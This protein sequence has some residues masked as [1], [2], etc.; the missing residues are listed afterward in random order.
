MIEENLANPTDE[1]IKKHIDFYYNAL[2]PQVELKLSSLTETY[3]E[4]KPLLHKDLSSPFL[5]TS[6]LNYAL[7]RLPPSIFFAKKILILQDTDQLKIAG[8]I[9][10]SWKK[11]TALSRRRSTFYNF[12]TQTLAFL[13]SS[14]S[15]IDDLINLLIA[16]FLEMDKIRQL[17]EKQFNKLIKNEDYSQLGIDDKKWQKLKKIITPDWQKKFSSILNQNNLIIKLHSRQEE[18]YHQTAKNWWLTSTSGLPIL[19]ISSSSVYLVSSNLHSLSNI[20]GTFVYTKQNEIFNYMAQNF[21]N[22]YKKW[23]RIKSTGDELRVNDFLYYI[24]SKYFQNNPEILKEKESFE[25]GI[26]IKTIKLGDKLPCDMQSIPIS[27]ITKAITVDPYLNISNKEKLSQSQA[28]IININ[29][30]LGHS[31]YYILSEILKRLD[32]IKGIYVIGKAAILSGSIGD[33]QIPKLVFDERTGNNFLIKNVFNQESQFTVTKSRI[34]KNQKAVTVYGTFLESQKQLEA[35]MKDDFNIIEM[36][37][38]PCLNAIS[39]FLSKEKHTNE[40]IK[41]DQGSID[42]GIINYAS[43]N[44]LSKTLG[45]GPLAIKGA[46]PTYL[47]ALTVMQRIVDLELQTS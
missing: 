47:S 43:D 12:F 21:P 10:K 29:Y 3:K 44:P 33:I 30:P 36:E 22:L 17:K 32:K 2:K 34:L 7:S 24:S 38:G 23:Q 8:T 27:A 6:A 4:I 14:D 19:D 26:G 35:Y 37:S 20:V 18:K 9:A 16:Y 42:L 45:E 15:D 1:K 25:L 31:A 41:I 28:C 5:D 40:T 13:I 11:E 39:E 46:E